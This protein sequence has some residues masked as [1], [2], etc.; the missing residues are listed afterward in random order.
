MTQEIILANATLVLPEETVIGSV[1]VRD[2]TI[3]DL[4]QG[5]HVPSGAEDCGGDFVAP[6]L[7]EL[8]TD[9]L[10]R[11]MRP[12]PRVDWPHQAAIVAHDAELA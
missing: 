7:V 3:V 5:A 12:R 10:E 8:H 4:D 11:H 1:V 2:G 6:G 9:N